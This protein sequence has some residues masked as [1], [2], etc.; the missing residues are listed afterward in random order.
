MKIRYLC[1][2]A[3]LVTYVCLMNQLC[4][5]MNSYEEGYLCF[6]YLYDHLRGLIHS[7]VLIFILSFTVRGPS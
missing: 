2:G 3:F 6:S 1:W 7:N 4:V 5:Y